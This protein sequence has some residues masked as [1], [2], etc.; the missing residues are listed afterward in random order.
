M[1]GSKIICGSGILISVTMPLM[2]MRYI[3]STRGNVELHF[4]VC[5]HVCT[6]NAVPEIVATCGSAPK[7]RKP[8][9]K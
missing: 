1:F 3:V 5:A 6:E 9:K 7:E 8:R 4:F 2:M